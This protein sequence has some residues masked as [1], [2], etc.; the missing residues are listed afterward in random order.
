MVGNYRITIDPR[1]KQLY[2]FILSIIKTEIE[3]FLKKDIGCKSKANPKLLTQFRS[4]IIPDGQ[5]ELI[6]Q[7]YRYG[8]F[9]FEPVDKIETPAYK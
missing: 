9:H 3:T 2:P 1:T 4:G 7:R 6:E 8:V 5:H